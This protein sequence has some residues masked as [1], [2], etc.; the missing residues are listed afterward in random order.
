MAGADLLGSTPTRT[1]EDDT[2]VQ[3]HGIEFFWVIS[4]D[5]TISSYKKVK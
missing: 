5:S 4:L 3:L 1:V 2:V